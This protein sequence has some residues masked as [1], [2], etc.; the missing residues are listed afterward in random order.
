MSEKGNKMP[1]GH[2]NPAH[3]GGETGICE[4]EARGGT[5]PCKFLLDQMWGL[6]RVHGSNAKRM[7]DQSGDRL[8]VQVLAY[9]A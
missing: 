8:R 4:H 3:R 5:E 1:R 9:R 7:S 6:I 2:W